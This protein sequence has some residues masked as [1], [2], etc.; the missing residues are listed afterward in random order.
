MCDVAAARLLR[1]GEHCRARIACAGAPQAIV[2]AQVTAT[3]FYAYA[4][5]TSC[6]QTVP[7]SGTQ[8]EAVV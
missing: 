6:V 2:S 1:H 4:N 8:V 5:D 3:G 7:P